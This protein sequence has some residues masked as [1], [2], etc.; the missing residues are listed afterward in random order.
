MIKNNLCNGCGACAAICPKD[1]IEMVKNQKGFYQPDVDLRKC[2]N[3]SICNKVCPEFSS[4]WRRTEAALQC[5]AVA[6]RNDE[7][8]INSSS[9]GVFYEL[10]KAVIEEGGVAFGV[11]W[12]DSI[13]AGHIMIDTAD[14][15]N[16]LMKSKYVQSN[17]G[18]IF[19]TV[20]QELTAGKKV[21]FSGSP[22]QIAG[23]KNYLNCNYSNLI[24]VD[25]ICHGVP[26]PKALEKYHEFVEAREQG[27]AVLYDFRSKKN[28]W[29]T[30]SLETT[31][32]DNHTALEKASENSYYRAFLSNLCL[33]KACGNCKFNCLPR[34]S[35]I[36]LGDYWRVCHPHPRFQDD[37]GVSCVVINT[38]KGQGLFEAVSKEFVYTPSSISLIKEGNPFIDGHC[39]LHPRNEQFFRGLDTD[40][41]FDS[42]VNRLLKPTKSEMI[43]EIAKYKTDK[44]LQKINS[45]KV[46]ISQYV[47][48]KRRNRRL[49]SKD[50]TIISNNCWGG[51]IY[52]KYGLEYRSPTVGLYILGHDFVKLCSDWERYMKL[53]LEFIPWES[54]SYYYALKDKEKYPVAKLGDIE[55]YFMHYRSE[56]E[57]A[58]KWY[59]RAKRINPEK[60]IFKLSQREGCSKEDI[61]AFM[62]LPLKNKV[63]FAYDRVDGAVFVP[64][65]EG[66]A[67]DE[68][69]I[70][71]ALFDEFRLINSL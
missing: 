52:Q 37:K 60:M 38:E 47:A 55:I 32:P 65:L 2:I 1:A 50:F 63:C 61:E 34:A 30:L 45:V 59:R 5:F 35:D 70:I 69:P 66:F 58:E 23:L 31:F 22:C 15:L 18:K 40:E 48:V 21:L 43:S 12:T 39:K 7:I 6:N 9:G 71:E 62:A 26:S 16:L 44:A 27:A 17:V 11:A 46:L 25:Y 10:A 67:G 29:N 64:E 42:L 51:A 49:K 68:S 3:C 53:Q 41:P 57:A 4:Q 20:K 24:T 28:G 8:R 13:T 54:A 56:Q 33:N 14:K 19:R 36:T